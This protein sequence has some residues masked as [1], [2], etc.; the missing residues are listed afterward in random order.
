[1]MHCFV[2]E[3][4]E[5]HMHIHCYI[6]LR[7]FL[8]K[9][10][11]C[12]AGRH[13]GKRSALFVP[14]DSTFDAAE[15]ST[16]KFLAAHRGIK[17]RHSGISRL[18]ILFIL[19]FTTNTSLVSITIALCPFCHSISFGPNVFFVF[20]T[21]WRI[22]HRYHSQMCYSQPITRIRVSY[23]HNCVG[24][25]KKLLYYEQS[26]LYRDLLSSSA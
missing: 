22:I 9:L 3:K 1:M 5:N 14:R 16:F 2:L 8:L 4:K 20:G 24:G 15:I 13:R 11:R 17:D 21:R 18:G 10:E 25:K 23:F 7:V 6:S 12:P 26:D 19:R